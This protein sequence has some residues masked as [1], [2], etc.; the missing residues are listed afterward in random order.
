[1][2]GSLEVRAPHDQQC[3]AIQNISSIALTNDAQE[4]WTVQRVLQPTQMK[5]R[6][7]SRDLLCSRPS[8]AQF[9]HTGT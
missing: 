6:P 3:D 5:W 9:G 2:A 1:M 4:T 7:G 8:C